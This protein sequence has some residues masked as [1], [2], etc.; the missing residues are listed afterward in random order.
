MFS[1]FRPRHQIL[2]LVPPILSWYLQGSLVKISDWGSGYKYLLA[3]SHSNS[4]KSLGWKDFS[5]TISTVL[6]LRRFWVSLAILLSTNGWLLG[7]KYIYK[8]KEVG[9]EKMLLILLPL[10]GAAYPNVRGCSPVHL[11][12]LDQLHGPEVTALKTQSRPHFKFVLNLMGKEKL[13]NPVR[14]TRSSLKPGP[15]GLWPAISYGRELVEQ[16]GPLIRNNFHCKPWNCQVWIKDLRRLSY[17][18][19]LPE[20]ILT[21]SSSV[22]SQTLFQAHF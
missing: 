21:G 2:H 13:P 1:G 11:A 3:Q 5:S 18:P 19:L 14:L 7:S 9:E 12:G 15:C 10:I 8:R 22:Y 6:N 4:S 20:S 17:E 16:G